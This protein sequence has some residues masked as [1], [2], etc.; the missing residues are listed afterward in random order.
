MKQQIGKQLALLLA[1]VWRMYKVRKEKE[2][3][4]EEARKAKAKAAKGK[5]KKSASR[6]AS[7]AMKTMNSSTSV[8]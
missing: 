8:R 3:K 4:A 6:T 5:K 2:R 1:H 7:F